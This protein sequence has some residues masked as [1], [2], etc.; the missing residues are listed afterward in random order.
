MT[1]LYHGDCLEVLRG[2]PDE[3]INLTVTSPPYDNLR[4]YNGGIEQ[5][6]FEKF[7]AIATELYRVTT[8][9]G[10]V[11][12]VVAD[13]VIKGSE[14]GTSFMQALYF[15]ECGFN[16]HDTMIWEKDAINFPDP[17]RYGQCFEYMFVFA[18]G[19]PNTINKICDRQNK[20]AGT[21]VH[22]TSRS[23]DG[24]T[25]RKS[26]DKKSV[27]KQF[28]ARFNVWHLPGE[29][30]NK[31]GHP[32]V[33]P[34]AIANDHIVSWSNPNDTV[35]DPFMGSGTTGIAA[36]E[37][38]RKFIGIELDESYFKIAQARVSNARPDET[39]PAVSG[40]TEMKRW[41]DDLL[42]DCL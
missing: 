9:G 24:S 3:S 36:V 17:T 19:K 22:G 11:V 29:K 5:W 4:T 42:G 33:F 34:K 25:F 21:T 32:A 39:T 15:K 40:D 35:L 8:T 2:I 38:G 28:G 31:T 14:S 41:L 37:T 30:N 1:T 10:V 13:A 12:W 18:K 27:V 23:P 7:K 20:W 6:N 16:L 26:N